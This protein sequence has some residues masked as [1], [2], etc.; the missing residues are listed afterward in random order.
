VQAKRHKTLSPEWEFFLRAR[1]GDNRAWREMMD[2][3]QPRLLSLAF[4][5][6][7]SLSAAEDIVQETF[8]HAL[9]MKI[10]NHDGSVRGLLGTIA[11]R[12]ALKELK[13]SRRTAEFDNIEHED[14]GRNSLAG[15]IEDERG[16]MVAETIRGL[17]CTHRDI[18]VLR[19]YAGHSYEEIADLIELPIGTVKSRIFYGVKRCREILKDKGV[20]E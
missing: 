7:G 4:L 12:L 20:F 5:I 9:G 13:R 14:P 11:Y 8:L 17:D 16:R 1:K 3:Y 6:T 2:N 19:F 10:K 18:L 15:I